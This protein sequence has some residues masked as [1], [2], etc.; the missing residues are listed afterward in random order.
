M[1][2]RGSCYY[3]SESGSWSSEREI[4]VA[5]PLTSITCWSVK[6]DVKVLLRKFTTRDWLGRKRRGLIEKMVSVAKMM[7]SKWG[8]IFFFEVIPFFSLLVSDK[9]H[10]YHGS[11]SSLGREIINFFFLAPSDPL[12]PFSGIERKKLITG[13][14]RASI[15]V[16]KGK[17]S[18]WTSK[19]SISCLPVSSNAR[20]L[21]IGNVNERLVLWRNSKSEIKKYSL[22]WY[23]QVYWLIR[24]RES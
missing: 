1:E 3:A 2:V 8:K 13:Y 23:S 10:A 4:K 22:F 6:T 11:T 16:G 12:I 5:C 21:R 14:F 9:K 7:A 15:G 17:M 19:T 18:R 24:G 20:F